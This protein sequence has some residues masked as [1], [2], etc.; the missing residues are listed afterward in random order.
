MFENYIYLLGGAGAAGQSGSSVPTLVT[1]GLMIV[2]M[3]FFLIRPQSK[4]QKAAKLMLANLKNGDK[5]VTIGGI[6]GTITSTKEKMIV[7][8]VDANTQL[9]VMRESI[10]SVINTDIKDDKTV[11][12]N[13]TK[14]DPKKLKDDN[15]TGKE[16]K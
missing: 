7:I 10:A 8:K 13:K 3:Y 15:S 4:K 5:I 2:V 16:K 12:K 14:D 1:F 11:A 9:E 6:Y